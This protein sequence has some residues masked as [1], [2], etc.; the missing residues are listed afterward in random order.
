MSDSALFHRKAG[1][2]MTTQI[3]DQVAA[4]P[5]AS[6]KGAAHE[7][8]VTVANGCAPVSELLLMP[9]EQKH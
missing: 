2:H 6:G 5:G 4:G 7:E 1:G 3:P 8:D 9:S